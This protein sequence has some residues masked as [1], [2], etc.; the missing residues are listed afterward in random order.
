M[1]RK[2]YKSDINEYVEME[3]VAQYKFLGDNKETGNLNKGKTYDCVGYD[4]IN[5]ICIYKRGI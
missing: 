3:V 2:V 1:K 4:D 5:K